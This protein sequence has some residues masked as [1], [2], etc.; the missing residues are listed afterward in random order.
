M[1]SS[2]RRVAA[3]LQVA[4][5]P[6]VH[7][8]GLLQRRGQQHRTH[9]EEE[10]PHAGRQGA[11]H[12]VQVSGRNH[13][14][15][16]QAGW[17]AVIFGAPWRK[18]WLISLSLSP[19]LSPRISR[20]V[21]DKEQSSTLITLLLPYLHRGSNSQV[22]HAFLSLTK[23][24]ESSRSCDLYSKGFYWTMGQ[25]IKAKE[26]KLQFSKTFLTCW[27]FCKLKCLE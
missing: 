27:L 6:R 13:G 25:C 12:P 9:Q 10:E 20:F 18:R 8:A 14:D 2:V 17:I 16:G 23:A 4:A 3:G 22:A 24:W 15:G 1:S 11:Q 26:L 19:L 5:A 7:G 21:N